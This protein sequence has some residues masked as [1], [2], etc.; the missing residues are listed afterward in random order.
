[1]LETENWV[2][3]LGETN[4]WK[5]IQTWIVCV[6]FVQIGHTGSNFDGIEQ[7]W[8]DKISSTHLQRT[9]HALH[10]VRG[11]SP[12]NSQYK[13]YNLTSFSNFN[14]ILKLFFTHTHTHITYTHRDSHM[15]TPRLTHAHT[16]NTHT[17]NT[18][19]HKHHTHTDTHMHTHIHTQTHTHNYLASIYFLNLDFLLFRMEANIFWWR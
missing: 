7:K 4:Q 1:M 10:F 9:Y 19:T 3:P 15:H 16:H 14:L 2:S 13:Q 5:S 18:C 17:H 8:K 12:I 6:E 11:L